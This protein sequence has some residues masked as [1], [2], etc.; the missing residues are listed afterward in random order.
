[1]KTQG[2]KHGAGLG[3][4]RKSAPSGPKGARPTRSLGA[5]D[6]EKARDPEDAREAYES[7]IAPGLRTP[8][9]E[10]SFDAPKQSLIE[11]RAAQGAAA[12]I[13]ISTPQALALTLG[14]D[15]GF[16]SRV[17]VRYL[18]WLAS[19]RGQREATRALS[20]G[21]LRQRFDA[22]RARVQGGT[23]VKSVLTEAF[24]LIRETSRR[25]LG[26]EHYEVQLLAAMTLVDG[27]VA[28]LK[29]GEG[30]TLSAG[31]AA[32]LLALEGKGCHVVTTNTYLAARDAEDL[33]PLYQAL[34]LSVGV[35]DSAGQ[36][37]DDKRTAYAADITYGHC[38]TFAF[39]WLEDQ[40]WWREDWRVQRPLHVAIVDEVDDVLLDS[41]QQPLVLCGA[42]LPSDNLDRRQGVM[43][44]AS[45]I[46]AELD[47]PEN[48]VIY[49]EG[50]NRIPKI[51][52][53]GATRL[54]TLLADKLGLADE[55]KAVWQAENAELLFHVK[56]ALEARYSVTSG[57]E[58]IRDEGELVL[59]SETTGHP[60]PGGRLRHGLHEAVMVKEGRQL[61]PELS[62]IGLIS[63]QHY[64]G[65]YRKLAGTTGTARGGK[66]ELRDLYGLQVVE[67]PTN[68]PIARVDEPDAFF[69]HPALRD[70]AAVAD[71]LRTHETGQPVLVSTVHVNAS[72]HVSAR[73]A[74]PLL[75]FAD[76]MISSEPLLR[77]TL[78]LLAG[79]EALLAARPGKLDEAGR[80]SLHGPALELLEADPVG[81]ARVASFLADKGLPAEL[82]LAH[83][84]GIPHRT[85]NA[86]TH[87]E[88]ATI[89]GAAGQ[90]DAVTVATQMAGRGVDIPLGEGVKELGG[91]RVVAVEHKTNPR[92]D[93]QARGRAG[94]Q[95]TPGASRFYVSPS[96]EVFSFLPAHKLRSLASQLSADAVAEPSG[97]LRRAWESAVEHSQKR[98]E[99]NKEFERRRS[100]K[101]DKIIRTQRMSIIETRQEILGSVELAEH[102][103]SWVHERLRG[104]A[105]EVMKVEPESRDVRP[106]E[107]RQILFTLSPDGALAPSE[108]LSF[109]ALLARADALIDEYTGA[110]KQLAGQDDAAFNQYLRDTI[111]FTLDQAWV[112]YLLEQEHQ[113]GTAYLAAY[114]ERDPWVEYT[115]QA[116]E[117]FQDM[118]RDVRK[119]AADRFMFHLETS[120][121]PRDTQA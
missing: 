67:V 119:S 2:S 76:V 109:E 8:P 37:Y 84:G 111:L 21:E 25:V 59:V 103:R 64:F 70:L 1:M 114:G 50:E 73:L 96:D 47:R 48:V 112:S 117:A 80:R 28:Q 18:T 91:L 83:A 108:P 11:T 61:E 118:V 4:P 40:V 53:E 66:D 98:A 54:Q 51:S 69:P 24:A 63:Y 22:L 10:A 32:A 100:T 116:A 15:N 78:P 89:I 49:F 85:L 99:L 23:P 110:S 86:E 75:T 6:A 79:G 60:N 20:D 72:K 56:K 35:V 31:L 52:D 106:E 102:L 16:K 93:D 82:I 13:E 121:K 44:L 43:R 65:A 88:E 26:K 34:G 104:L 55:A 81:R 120:S 94:R 39:D 115:R 62:T 12:P 71:V 58:Y 87:K 27:N 38:N 105:A 42:P 101:L 45:E 17:P 19:I 14:L 90:K 7:L 95:G 92:K 3:L 107:A 36:S 74:R 46:A 33:R 29:T 9:G 113:K 30:K 97:S 5:L 41:A 57:K 68:K 77:K